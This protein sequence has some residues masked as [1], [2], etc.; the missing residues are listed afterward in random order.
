M[1]FLVA[2]LLCLILLSP[3]YA[4]QDANHNTFQDIAAGGTDAGT[5]A[6]ARTNI[7][8]V[9]DPSV[10]SFM[11]SNGSVL[12]WATTINVDV[13]LADEA[14]SEGSGHITYDATNDALRVYDGAAVDTFSNDAGTAT[15]TNKTMSGSSNT[16]TNIPLGT[17]VTGQLVGAQIVDNAITNTKMADDAIGINELSATGT[18]DS[19]TYL[20]GDNTWATVSSGTGGDNVSVNSSAV[21]DPDFVST[22]SISFTN[23][24]NT[25]SANLDDNAVTNAKI[26][27]DAVDSAE[28]ADGA[29][30]T[31]HLAD[32]VVTMDKIDDDGAFT[33]L[34]GA[35]HTTGVLQGKVNTL[36]YSANTT[37]SAANADGSFIIATAAMTLTLP[38]AA[39]G[40]SLC[41]YSGQGSTAIIQIAPASGDYIVVDGV[42]GTAATALASSGAAGDSI[43]VI[44]SGTDDWYVTSKVGTWDE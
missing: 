41:M 39:S 42:R 10:P 12:S 17:A 21:T 15:L 28:I 22:G 18:A 35:W 29:I 13:I 34:T 14:P 9:A 7:L 38:T 30:D 19:T 16:F 43:C 8:G 2:S 44:S 40:Y 31:V 25:I 32:D 5:A 27:D 37:L 6:G 33:S 1:R 23:S 36:S 11:Y 20:R 4:V 3:A 24:S 26:V